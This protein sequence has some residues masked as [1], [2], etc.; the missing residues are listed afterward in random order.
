MGRK[1]GTPVREFSPEEIR[2]LLKFL[3]ESLYG[4]DDEKNDFANDE[5]A[6]NEAIRKVDSLS[7]RKAS[8]I[9]NL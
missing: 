4:A 2:G 3:I 5:D 9:K 8:D 1:S 7:A 6:F